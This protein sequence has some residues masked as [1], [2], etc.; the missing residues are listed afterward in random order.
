MVDGQ[1]GLNLEAV[2][3]L[4]ELELKDMLDPVPIP[5]QP[6]V[7]DHAQVAHQKQRIV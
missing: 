5:N 4:A 3:S 2:L 1:L 7:V 6:M